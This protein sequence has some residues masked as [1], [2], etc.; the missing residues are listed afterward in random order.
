MWA[1]IYEGYEQKIKKKIQFGLIQT[2]IPINLQARAILEVGNKFLKITK[3]YTANP[4]Q[5]M[6]PII[7]NMWVH[8][9]NIVRQGFMLLLNSS[10]L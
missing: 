7:N 10:P 2:L 6:K 9:W 4:C 5:N 3:K 8:T 1:T